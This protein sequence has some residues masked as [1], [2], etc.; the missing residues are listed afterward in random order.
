MKILIIANNQKWKSWNKKIQDI[1]DWFLPALELKIDIIHSDI[2]DIPVED[3]FYDNT[4][5]KIINKQ[6]YKQNITEKYKDYDLY[7]H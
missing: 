2:K 4:T 6:W 3:V 1:I 5:R 7:H